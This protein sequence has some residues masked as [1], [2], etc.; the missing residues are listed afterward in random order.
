MSASLVHSRWE[1]GRKLIMSCDVINYLITPLLRAA[2]TSRGTPFY[3]DS[4]VDLVANI[5][6]MAQKGTTSHLG[7]ATG[8]TSGRVKKRG[9]GYRLPSQSKYIVELVYTFFEKEKQEQRWL[10]HNQVV[11]HKEYSTL[12]SLLQLGVLK[13]KELFKC[14]CTTLWKVVCEMGFRY[15][16]TWE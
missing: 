4:M 2:T 13:A 6:T 5:C 8:Y 9:R 15:K 14:G 1:G 16:K 12:D 11:K 10:L 7:T 3:A